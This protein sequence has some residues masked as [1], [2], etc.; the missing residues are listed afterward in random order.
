LPL[1][2]AGLNEVPGIDAQRLALRT[3]RSTG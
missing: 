3:M 2:T 1:V